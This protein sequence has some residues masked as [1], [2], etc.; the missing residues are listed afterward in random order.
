VRHQNDPSQKISLAQLPNTPQSHLNP[1]SR[2]R[3]I[4]I[5]QKIATPSRDICVHVKNVYRGTST[6]RL[7]RISKFFFYS[8]STNR[9]ARASQQTFFAPGSGSRDSRSHGVVSAQWESRG[10]ELVFFLDAA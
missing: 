3:D 7:H 9:G 2:S 6:F 10:A 8:I 5:V 4:R 1:P